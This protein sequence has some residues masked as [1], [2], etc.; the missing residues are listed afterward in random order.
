MEHTIIDKFFIVVKGKW[1]GKG[2]DSTIVNV[3]GPHTDTN[4]QKLWLSLESLVGKH[5]TGWVLCGD[6][7]K[8]HDSS[9]RQNCD[10]IKRRANW[11]N[12]F[13]NKTKLIDVP[14]GGK[15]FTRI[16]NNGIKFSKLDRFLIS[17]KFSDIWNELLVLAL[18]R[19]LSNHYPIILRDTAIDFGPIPT[20]VFDEWFDL[21]GADDLIS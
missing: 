17:E 15:R 5:D 18:E 20:K 7:N 12:N 3:Y 13:I 19:K 1:K 9:E 14:M 8:V 21:E 4:K 6:F 16:C 11:F 2:V 10:F